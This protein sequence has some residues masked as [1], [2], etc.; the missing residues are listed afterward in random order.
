MNCGQIDVCVLTKNK[1]TKKILVIECK[2]NK[3]QVS[4]KQRVRLGRTCE[5]LGQLFKEEVQFLLK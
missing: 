5:L 1:K 4:R 2:S 3:G